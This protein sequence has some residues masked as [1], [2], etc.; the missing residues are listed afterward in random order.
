MK[1]KAKSIL[2]LG[3]I[4]LLAIGVF[5]YAVVNSS[6]YTAQPSRPVTVAELQLQLSDTQKAS[7]KPAANAEQKQSTQQSGTNP[8][9]QSPTNSQGSSKITDNS[10]PNTGPGSPVLLFFG[11]FLFSFLVFQAVQRQRQIKRAI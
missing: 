11:T 5:L 2:G 1:P 9:P 10:L 3:V 6:N 7:S 4:G 8:T